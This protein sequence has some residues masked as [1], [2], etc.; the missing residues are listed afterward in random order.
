MHETKVPLTAE[1][2]RTHTATLTLSPADIG[3]IATEDRVEITL[4]IGGIAKKVV[5][6][7][8]EVML[9]VENDRWR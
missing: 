8:R 6:T 1:S 5:L 3:E 9:L 2:V 7:P 4:R